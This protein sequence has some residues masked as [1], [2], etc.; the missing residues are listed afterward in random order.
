MKFGL[1]FIGLFLGLNATAQ[2]YRI[3][4]FNIP[5]IKNTTETKFIDHSYIVSSSPTMLKDE[6]FIDHDSVD[7]DRQFTSN[8]AG[9]T[10]LYTVSANPIQQIY[11]TYQEY[12]LEAEKQWGPMPPEV[13]DMNTL[14]QFLLA[15][16][17][18]TIQE[19]LTHYK[20]NLYIQNPLTPNSYQGHCVMNEPKSFGRIVKDAA[21]SSIQLVDQ[22]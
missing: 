20:M 17:G 4:V 16:Y 14:K 1:I 9:P 18:V 8:S 2:T 3:V 5:V 22:L 10:V 12:K 13:V 11:L 6:C 19:G 15:R 7:Y 21:I